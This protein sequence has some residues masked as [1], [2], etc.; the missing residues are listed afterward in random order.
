LNL[1]K[2]GDKLDDSEKKFMI[3]L[4]KFHHNSAEKIK[5][6]KEIIV[7]NHPSF[8]NTRCFIIVKNDGSKV[9]FSVA[10]CVDGIKEKAK[11]VEASS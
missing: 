1:K 11:I 4:L 6:L 7:D 9:D 8:A 3:D 2:N 10:K 5:D